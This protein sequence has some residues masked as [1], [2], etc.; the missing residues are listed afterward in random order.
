[1][2]DELKVEYKIRE[3]GVFPVVEKSFHFQCFS[4][5]TILS[6]VL[7]IVIYKFLS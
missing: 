7:F 6:N 2:S 1:M 3:D 4:L 5:T